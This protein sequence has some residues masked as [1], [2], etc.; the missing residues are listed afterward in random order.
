MKPFSLTLLVISL[1]LCPGV[2]ARAEVFVWPEASPEEVDIDPGMIAD[3]VAAIN[4]GDYG[5]LKSLLILRHGR[6]V[7][8]QYF[9]GYRRDQLMPL[10][11][12][13]KSWASALTGIGIGR[14]DLPGVDASI[15]QVFPGYANIFSLDPEKSSIRLQ[16]ILTMRHGLE[17]DEW[18]LFFTNPANP[19]YQMTRSDDWWEYVLSR[20][21]TAAPGS[22][23][24]YS[25]GVSNLLGG[26][27]W[28]LT[29]MS[30]LDY[31]IEHLFSPLDI[32]D[33]YLEVDLADKPRGS[34]IT[35]FQQGLTPTGHGLW[36]K[37][38]DLAKIGQ[39]YLD[40]GAWQS[41]RILASAWIDESWGSFSNHQ[42][43]PDVFPDNVSYGYQW[44]TYRFQRP[45][46]EIV[47]QTA[48][49]FADQYI[50][51]IPQLDMVIASTADNG[52]HQGEDLRF[53]LRDI[54]FDGVDPDFDPVADGGLTGSWFNPDLDHQG[55]MLEVVPATGQVVIY[56]MT[57]EPGSGDQQWM[58]AVGQMH[59]RRAVLEFLQPEGGN[60][61]GSGKASLNHWGDVEL[62]FHS[63][64][65]AS[66]NFY[67]EVDG[68]E[69]S[70]ELLRL[71][72]NTICTEQ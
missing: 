4:R 17:W 25:T 57:F 36:L 42:T 59:G 35:D 58:V 1:L 33:Y 34:G 9:N 30:A 51:V 22:V 18:S 11:S 50:F 14:G 70:I 60:F 71:T 2:S 47:V 56:W 65:Q 13:T 27:I 68:V 7:H 41:R 37:P 69:G 16:D 52:G 5:R 66:M 28:G 55:F 38:R 43:D 49:G 54:I 8:E 3:L 62:I 64:T 26:A 46:G 45:E 23:F 32:Q 24:R 15:D 31:S 53:A 21:L 6:L 29:G 44:W 61:V 12:V 19:V 20:P 72:P 40:R 39:L 10:Y 63:C 48:D 67:S